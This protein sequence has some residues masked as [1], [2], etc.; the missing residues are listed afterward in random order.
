MTQQRVQRRELVI[1]RDPQ[2]LKYP[3]DTQV[4]FVP[5]DARQGSANGLRERSCGC[6]VISCERRS[7]KLSVRF[8][9][10]IFQQSGEGCG[11]GLLQ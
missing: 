6:K 7:E 11:F 2:R 9:G 8:V 10:I 5:R 1:H 4:L 3:P